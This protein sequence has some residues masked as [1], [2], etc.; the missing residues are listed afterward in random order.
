MILIKINKKFS[1]SISIIIVLVAIASVFINN[2][3]ISKYYLHQ[4]KKYLDKIV[5]KLEEDGLES[6][7]KIENDHDLI[8]AYT[9][10]DQDIDE[11]NADIIY[12]FEK[13]KVK[14][15]KFWIEEK[16]LENLYTKN[17]NR[18]YDQGKP[19]YSFLTKFI[20]ID[21]YVVAIGM[22]IPHLDETI[23]IIN[24]F[25][26]YLMTFSLLLIGI[27]VLIFSR[28]ITRS[29]EKLRLLSKDIASLNFRTENIKTNDEIEDLAKS[30]NS[31]SMTLEEAHNE[32]NAQNENLKTMLSDTSH[33]LKTPVALIKVYARGIEDGLDDGTYLETI[34]E[35]TDNMEN[36]IERLLYWAKLERN[37]LNKSNFDINNEL[38]K[39]LNKYKLILEENNIELLLKL[40]YENEYNVYG[41][42]ESINI[43]L[44]NL[45][46]NSIKYTNNKKIKIELLNENGVVKLLISNAVDNVT[47]EQLNN[48]WK[49]FY[50]IEKSR[51]KE[52]SGTGLGLPIVKTILE[53]HKFA[54]NV[55]INNE[56]IEFSIYFK[57]S[58]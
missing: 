27:L 46:T 26:I 51:S 55:E 48:I 31:M 19:K 13:K 16:G 50:V 2:I 58:Y 12:Q 21:K 57:E 5:V 20:I 45:I 1:I 56:N 49:P 9:K 30:I 47:K 37:M 4:K 11:I 32:L 52:L 43:V 42:K 53:N 39:T 54:F 34:L 35:Q 24:Q 8:I 23:A 22:S 29:I 14:L 17:V 38:V 18:I 3:F 10:L 33:E 36:L 25:N 41:D 40:D 44:N 7:E 28:K 6:I 15:N